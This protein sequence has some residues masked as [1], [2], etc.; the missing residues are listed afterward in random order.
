MSEPRRQTVSHTAAALAIAQKLMYLT[1]I[2]PHRDSTAPWTPSLPV[3]EGK[4]EFEED[5][6]AEVASKGKSTADIKI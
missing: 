6:E 1:M 4:Q 3:R 5:R 2:P